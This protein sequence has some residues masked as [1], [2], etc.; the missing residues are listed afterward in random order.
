MIPQS[1]S[2]GACQE[3]AIALAGTRTNRTA[4]RLFSA[5]ILQ[6]LSALRAARVEMNSDRRARMIA[7][8][9][10]RADSQYYNLPIHRQMLTVGIACKRNAGRDAR[11]R[12]AA[13]LDFGQMTLPR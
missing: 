7:E 5:D 12:R 8:V 9:L 10:R 2:L 4:V 6:E 13:P 1:R 3:H 11:Q